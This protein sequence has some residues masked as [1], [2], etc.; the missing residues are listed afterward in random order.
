M[1][2]WSLITPVGSLFK[3]RGDGQE[4]HSLG[5]SSSPLQYQ[6]ATLSKSIKTPSEKGKRTTPKILGQN[7]K[8]FLFLP[9]GR[10]NCME[11]WKG[12]CLRREAE[13]VPNSA[14]VLTHTA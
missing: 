14:L 6:V 8:V 2:D 4:A 3:A 13:M 11:N 10:G 12:V 1:V 5:A 7:T 9:A